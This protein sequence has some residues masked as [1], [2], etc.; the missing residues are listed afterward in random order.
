MPASP[1]RAY[2]SRRPELRIV[3]RRSVSRETHIAELLAQTGEAKRAQVQALLQEFVAAW[4]ATAR[5][6]AIVSW[7]SWTAMLKPVEQYLGQ[8][9]LHSAAVTRYLLLH[10]LECVLRP[11][12][13]QRASWW[14]NPVW[15]ALA[16]VLLA[17]A[18]LHYR[19][20][21]AFW[22]AWSAFA[23]WSVTRGVSYLRSWRI[24][25]S[26]NA[27][28]REIE[29]SEYLSSDV[30]SQICDLERRR[31]VVPTLLYSLLAR[32]PSG[33]KTDQ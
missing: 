7:T 14:Q 8:A 18:G 24:A 26:G 1:K 31:V 16:V 10:M 11:F 20:R 25:R 23:V 19:L 17:F 12:R 21:A 13:A 9:E 6:G 2:T 5:D 27:V 3:G 33:P 30:V 28:Q 4:Q 32:L 15:P 22:I 29:S